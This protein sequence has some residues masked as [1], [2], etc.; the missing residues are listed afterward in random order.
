MPGFFLLSCMDTNPF[1]EIRRIAKLHDPE[2]FDRRFIE[3]VPEYR[4]M[5]EAYQ[6]VEK[7]YKFLFEQTKYSNYNSYRVTRSVRVNRMLKKDS[8]D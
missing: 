8:D 4:T 7:E 3:L 2:Q 6:A 1:D 5:K